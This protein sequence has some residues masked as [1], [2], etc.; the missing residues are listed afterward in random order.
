MQGTGG[1]PSPKIA[2]STF[3]E[4]VLELLTPEA[5]G[6][7]NIPEDG[8]NMEENLILEPNVEV[9]ENSETTKQ[10]MHMITEKDNR[11]KRDIE[12]ISP[13]N[14]IEKRRKV[15]TTGGNLCNK[16]NLTY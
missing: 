9:S 6:L 4:E 7:G 14:N 3:E 10:D 1:G 13:Y 5:A 15:N 8:I 12:N 2:F 16:N 11:N